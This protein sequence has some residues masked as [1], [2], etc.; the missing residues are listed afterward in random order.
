MF[1]KN[2]KNCIHDNKTRGIDMK[3]YV[4][5]FSKCFRDVVG[6]FSNKKK[7]NYHVQNVDI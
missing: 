5:F 7:I 1:N 6:F 2:C 3:C 4:L